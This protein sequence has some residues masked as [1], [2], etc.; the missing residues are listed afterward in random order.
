MRRQHVEAGGARAVARRS[1]P[2]RSAPR[3]WRSRGPARRAPR[4][5]GRVPRNPRPKGPSSSGRAATNADPSRPRPTTATR[6]GSTGAIIAPSGE[7]RQPARVRRAGCRRATSRMAPL[8]PPPSLLAQQDR[9]RRHLLDRVESLDPGLVGVRLDELL[10]GDAGRLGS[11]GTRGP[12]DVG[13]DRAGA[14]RVAG[15]ALAP[16]SKAVALV[17]PLMACLL[18]M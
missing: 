15:D 11:L 8:M 9:H 1:G 7:H 4:H 13:L 10:V 12:H 6:P 14:D 5:R 3:R 18:V 2:A 17:R 16:Y